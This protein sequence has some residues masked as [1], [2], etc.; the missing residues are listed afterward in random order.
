MASVAS[1][2]ADPLGVTRR[3]SGVQSRLSAG[4]LALTLCHMLPNSSYLRKPPEDAH[5]EGLRHAGARSGSARAVSNH[6]SG[7]RKRTS[8]PGKC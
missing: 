3:K 7:A 6:I 8:W 1:R 2:T 4:S 5:V